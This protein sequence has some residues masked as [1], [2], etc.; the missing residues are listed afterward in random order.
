VGSLRTASRFRRGRL[1][2]LAFLLAAA[3]ACVK[4]TPPALEEPA[5]VLERFLFCAT[6]EQKEDWAEAGPARSAFAPAEDGQVYAFV[7]FRDLRGLHALAWKWY[8]PSGK[9]RRAP[10]AISIGEEGKSFASYIA[11][12]AVSLDSEMERGTWT[13]ALFLDGALLAEKRFEVR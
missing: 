1:A 6:V 13:V 7:E 8:V 3:A 2:A 11:W 12:D 9:L 10:E 5:A 4:F